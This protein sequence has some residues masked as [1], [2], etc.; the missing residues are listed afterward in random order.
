LGVATFNR[1]LESGKNMLV[2]HFRTQLEDELNSGSMAM[3]S[4]FSKS[5]AS[6]IVGDCGT[7]QEEGDDGVGFLVNMEDW[8]GGRCYY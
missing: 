1:S 4:C 7:L 5:P 6:M 8:D 2:V 3:P